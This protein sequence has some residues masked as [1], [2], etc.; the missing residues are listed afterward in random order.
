M[1]SLLKI[2]SEKMSWQDDA[3]CR[4]MDTNI[5]FPELGQTL[6]AFVK[7]VCETCPVIEE[8]FWYANETHCSEGYFGGM[9]ARDR[10]RWRT[11]HGVELGMSRS[12]YESSR[13][14]KENS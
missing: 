14:V 9:A 8:C 7:E 3:N 1:N 5:F 11:E 4:N 2:M 13:Q 10:Q 6:P 12:Q